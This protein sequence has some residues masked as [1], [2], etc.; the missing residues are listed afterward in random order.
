MSEKRYTVH[1]FEDVG[2][3]HDDAQ[4]RVLH[5]GE[6][7][8]YRGARQREGN[9]HLVRQPPAGKTEYRNTRTDLHQQEPGDGVQSMDG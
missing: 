9:H 6:Q 7:A 1:L 5:P 4:P 8:V 2:T 3:N